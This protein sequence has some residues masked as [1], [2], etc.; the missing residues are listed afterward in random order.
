MSQIGYNGA[1]FRSRIPAMFTKNFVYDL[2]GRSPVRPLQ[3]HMDKVQVCVA[4]LPA[5]FEAVCAGDWDKAERSSRRWRP[6]SAR[7]T[8]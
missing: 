7:P 1:S 5:F 2:F 8:S 4:E 3:T 6:W